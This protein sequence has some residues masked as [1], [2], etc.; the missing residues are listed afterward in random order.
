[1]ERTAHVLLL[2]LPFRS[3]HTTECRTFQGIPAF[4]FP[5]SVHFSRRQGFRAGNPVLITMRRFKN[6]RDSRGRVEQQGRDLFSRLRRCSRRRQPDCDGI[7][8]ILYL[9]AQ[10]GNGI[11]QDTLFTLSIVD[12]VAA[13]AYQLRSE[14]HTSEL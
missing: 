12:G 6:L 8:Y 9:L 14:E 4:A 2:L 1:M 5:F 7:F 3:L 13:L 10:D 11:Y